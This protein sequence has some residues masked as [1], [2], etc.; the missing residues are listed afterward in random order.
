MIEPL[1]RIRTSRRLKL[2]SSLY[3]F[4]N[5]DNMRLETTNY[6]LNKPATKNSAKWLT[7]VIGM[8]VGMNFGYFRSLTFSLQ[9]AGATFE[10][11]SLFMLA[12]LP[13]SFRIL[14]G[15][16]TDSLFIQ[17]LGRNKTTVLFS[18]LLMFGVQLC[19]A[20]RFDAMITQ[21]DY[22]QIALLIFCL[23]CSFI[24]FYSGTD[25]LMIS[26]FPVDFRP[27]ISRMSDLGI[28][29]G[30]FLAYNVFLPLNTPKF[31]NRMLPDSVHID[32]PIMTHKMLLLGQAVALLLLLL[33]V[34]VCFAEVSHS[35]SDDDSNEANKLSVRQVFNLLSEFFTC[36]NLRRLVIYVLLTRIFRQTASGL[37]KLKFVEYGFTKADL[38]NADTIGFPVLVIVNTFVL[39]RELSSK[40]FRLF[41]WMVYI[42]L[43]AA[44]LMLFG[45]TDYHN[46]HIRTRA[47]AYLSISSMLDKITARPV[48][49]NSFIYSITP[50]DSPSTFVGFFNSLT[51]LSS[52]LPTSLGYFLEDKVPFNCEVFILACLGTQLLIH[53]I[54]HEYASSLDA[55]PKENFGHMKEEK[56]GLLHRVPDD[57][58]TDKEFL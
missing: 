15:P 9:E 55:V 58:E 40:P 24:F 51:N 46:H 37:L 2:E 12:Q 29:S 16:M 45:L 50:S 47:Y 10:D 31:L 7:F 30:E 26:S 5:P 38:A 19:L 3:E 4:G 34:V 53:L 39:K 25:S 17:K 28:I 54:L 33:Y 42:N 18:S 41:H 48:F 22:R 57:K 49:L 44:G 8:L 23:N 14:V 27:N 13:L 43:L 11:Q 1:E 21:K 32:Q 20:L 52:T 35:V 36:Q 56:K 6:L